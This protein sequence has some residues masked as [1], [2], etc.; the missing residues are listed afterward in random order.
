MVLQLATKYRRSSPIASIQAGEAAGHR[1]KW[2]FVRDT[3]V[4]KIWNNQKSNSSR[5]GWK[6]KSG[7]LWLHRWSRSGN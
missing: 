7:Q 6:R 1:G 5:E 3:Y 2:F 4:A